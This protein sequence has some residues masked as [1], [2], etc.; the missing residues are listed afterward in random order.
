MSTIGQI[1]KQTQARV[2]ALF[3]DRLGYDYLGNWID[4]SGNANIEMG[5]LPS[6]LKKQG[7]ENILINRA[8][9]EPQRI[10]EKGPDAVNTLPKSIGKNEEAVAETI[11]NN[12]RRIITNESPVDPTYYEQISKLLDALIE[13]RRKSAVSYHDTWRRSQSWLGM[14]QCQVVDRATRHR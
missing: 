8:M 13:Q 9:L 2:V 7:V 5:L 11:E 1:E 4:R 6:W 3:R 12:V 14:R 10:V